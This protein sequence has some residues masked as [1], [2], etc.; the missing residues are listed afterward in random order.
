[1]ST[2]L[3][4]KEG[5]LSGPGLL[6]LPSFFYF[7]LSRESSHTSPQV[8][9][10]SCLH[11]VS[12]QVTGHT[13]SPFAT[14]A[15]NDQRPLRLPVGQIFEAFPTSSGSMISHQHSILLAPPFSTP[16]RRLPQHP[17]TLQSLVGRALGNLQA[18]FTSITMQVNSHF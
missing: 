8:T 9:P 2:L 12:A 4:L 18:A 16:Y 10:S 14:S 17:S 1:M 15:C 7:P 6:H 5:G 13:I 11:L 3:S